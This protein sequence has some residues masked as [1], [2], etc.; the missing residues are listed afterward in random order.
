[1]IYW[2]EHLTSQEAVAFTLGTLAVI[3]IVTAVM[4]TVIEGARH[5]CGSKT[6]IKVGQNIYYCCNCLVRFEQITKSAEDK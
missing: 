6:H 4:G 3:W 5:S 2:L 1:M